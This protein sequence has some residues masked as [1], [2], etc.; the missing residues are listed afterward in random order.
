MPRNLGCITL[1]A[2]AATIGVLPRAAFACSGTACSAVSAPTPTYDASHN[3]AVVTLTNKDSTAA[4]HVK[5]TVSVDGHSA[6]N[7]EKD[8]AAK[9]TITLKIPI[10]PPTPIK[11]P[12]PVK[13]AINVTNADFKGAQNLNNNVKSLDTPAGRL[14]YLVVQEGKWGRPLAITAEHDRKF[15]ALFEQLVARSENMNNAFK[16]LPLNEI[17]Q[18][19][20]KLNA[21]NLGLENASS[22][23]EEAGKQADGMNTQYQTILAMYNTANTNFEVAAN[24][25]LLDQETQA[26]ADVRQAIDD[27]RKAIGQ[28]AFYINQ[29]LNVSANIPKTGV[30]IGVAVANFATRSSD[31]LS[32]FE[33]ADLAG[34]AQQLA[35]KIK[36]DKQKNLKGQMMAASANFKEVGTLLAAAKVKVEAFKNDYEKKLTTA[37]DR[38]D[39][40]NKGGFQFA[41]LKATLDEAGAV[42]VLATQVIQAADE[43][44]AS[45]SALKSSSEWMADPSNDSGTLERMA[46]FLDAKGNQAIQ[47]RQDSEAKQTILQNAYAKAM[48]VS[49]QS[50]TR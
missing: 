13:A 21:G 24:A 47:W 23:A 34:R 48:Q 6:M 25:L 30:K 12:S 19:I 41:K 4:V 38:F 36:S 44:R 42:K 3:Q 18:Q 32:L 50:M 39:A 35:D 1:F 49:G 46:S 37:Q 8:L 14:T 15:M 9:E 31:V 5:F 10:P 43:T 26:Y 40:N 45:I 28:V 11:P 2:A 29:V 17:E 33:R 7:A 22:I 27:Q 20:R 16:D